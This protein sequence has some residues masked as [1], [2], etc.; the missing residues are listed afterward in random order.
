MLQVIHQLMK[1]ER[2]TY[3]HTAKLSRA[4]LLGVIVNGRKPEPDNG[5]KAPPSPFAGALP[6]EKNLHSWKI[7]GACP[8]SRSATNYASVAKVSAPREED[9][10]S[11]L[12]LDFETSNE[13]D[14]CIACLAELV[15]YNH[16][17]CDTLLRDGFDG[18][19]LRGTLPV[20]SSKS[21][22]EFTTETSTEEKCLALAKANKSG[23]WGDSSWL[24][25]AEVLLTP[26]WHFTVLSWE[27]E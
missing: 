2:Y 22:K 14:I 1:E 7:C 12:T 24:P 9:I 5:L 10:N 16:H 17:C 23:Q 11:F 4:D 15:A 27:C 18:D 13:T 3:L 26:T 6:K 25:K 19:V 21:L 8:V 20:K